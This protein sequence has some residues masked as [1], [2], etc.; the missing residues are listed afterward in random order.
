MFSWGFGHPNDGSTWRGWGIG[1]ISLTYALSIDS[2]FRTSGWVYVSEEMF[3]QLCYFNLLTSITIDCWSDKV[4]SFCI[5]WKLSPLPGASSPNC[6]PRPCSPEDLATPR[7]VVLDVGGELGLSV[8]HILSIDA[9][10]RTSRWV[11]VSEGFVISIY[12]QALLQ[13]DDQ[14]RWVYFAFFL[15]YSGSCFCCLELLHP[16]AYLGQV[17][18]RI[19]PPQWQ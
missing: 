11:S 19:W 15:I 2:Q 13:I 6:P 8:S 14:T 16:I 3:C 9:Q 10:F 17:L 1:F 4:S 7:T 12:S 5:F 18:L